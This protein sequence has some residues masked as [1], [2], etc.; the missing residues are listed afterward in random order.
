[1]SRQR[2]A[3]LSNRASYTRYML[4][5]TVWLRAT[6]KDSLQGVLSACRTE[7]KARIPLHWRRS[8]SSLPSRRPLFR[9]CEWPSFS[10]PRLTTAHLVIRPRQ[11]DWGCLGLG[12]HCTSAIRKQ[13]WHDRHHRCLGVLMTSVQSIQVN[14]LACST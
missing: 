10:F 11:H 3:S 2:T 6:I 8:H 14:V 13:L 9:F 7:T 12:M 4:P 5:K 1:M